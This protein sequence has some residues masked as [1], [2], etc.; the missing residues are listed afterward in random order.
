MAKKQ[1]NTKIQ[2]ANK[3]ILYCSSKDLYYPTITIRNQTTHLAGYKRGCG[4]YQEAVH[5]LDGFWLAFNNEI[6]GTKAP[7]RPKAKPVQKPTS[8]KPKLKSPARKNK[9]KN[10]SPKKPKSCRSPSKPR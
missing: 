1:Q 4:T 3:N 7:R 2:T 6:S 8:R 9:T 10:T 5:A